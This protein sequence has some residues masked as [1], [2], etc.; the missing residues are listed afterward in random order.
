MG[1]RVVIAKLGY[2]DGQ[3][4]VAA[5]SIQTDD[6]PGATG[7][8]LLDRYP[9]EADA[10][11]LLNQGNLTSSLSL[12]K[13]AADPAQATYAQPGTV[14]DLLQSKWLGSAAPPVDLRP[15]PRHLVVHAGHRQRDTPPAGSSPHLIPPATESPP[16]YPPRTHTPNSV[17]APSRLHRCN[18]P[19]DHALQFQHTAGRWHCRQ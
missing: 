12:S 13:A 5:I 2:R 18:T 1:D 11:Q 7:R 14:E 9:Q 4:F 17:S 15:L 19:G 10:D 3:P 6:H 16:P 8:V